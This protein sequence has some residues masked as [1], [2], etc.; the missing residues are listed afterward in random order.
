MK[1][2]KPTEVK[3]RPIKVILQ[4]PALAMV[5]LLNK[6]KYTQS[7]RIGP[8]RTQ[9][10]RN[11]IKSLMAQLKTEEDN[12]NKNVRLKY[13]NGIPRFFKNS[14]STPGSAVS[15]LSENLSSKN[16]SGVP[17]GPQEN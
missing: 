16:K 12:G 3:I 9:M 11:H 4:H 13:V 2:A 14:T 6:K 15:G 1:S 10:Q 5:I 7:S 8:D 17:T